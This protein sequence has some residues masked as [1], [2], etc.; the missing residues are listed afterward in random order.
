M[1]IESIRQPA[2]FLPFAMS[3]V[4]LGMVLVHAALFGVTRETDEGT[5]AHIFQLLMIAQAPLI[6]WFALKSL[7]RDP[8][9]TL[10]I[11]ALQICAALAAILAAAFLT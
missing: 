6:I 11:L 2:A 5:A 3:L 8:R 4:A 1:K 7:W 10:L 9:G